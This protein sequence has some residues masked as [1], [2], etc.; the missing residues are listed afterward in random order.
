MFSLGLK[1]IAILV[2][3]SLFV[4]AGAFGYYK[5]AVSGAAEFAK[6]EQILVNQVREVKTALKQEQNRN[7]TCAADLT[8]QSASIDAFKKE[9]EQNLIAAQK[10][11][12]IHEAA[13]DKLR[14]RMLQIA[15]RPPS[16]SCS[17]AARRVIDELSKERGAN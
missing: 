3:L 11:A 8:V 13:A 4:G 1:P 6:K 7:A 15:K 2:A 10:R 12:A 16:K 5:G 9:A 14:Q 17:E